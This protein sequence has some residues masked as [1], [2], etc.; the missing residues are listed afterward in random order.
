MKKINVVV[1]V[2]AFDLAERGAGY[3]CEHIV[4]FE[5]RKEAELQARE[6]EACFENAL[7]YAQERF[8]DDVVLNARV[9]EI[10]VRTVDLW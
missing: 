6:H 7:E 3:R 9:E 5:S 1:T 10:I 4:A 2:L 8:D